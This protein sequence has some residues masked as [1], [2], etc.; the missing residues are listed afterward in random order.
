MPWS[1]F[2]PGLVMFGS[3][4][5]V[6]LFRFLQCSSA[7]RVTSRHDGAISMTP[8]TSL[9]EQD[10]SISTTQ[11]IHVQNMGVGLS[12]NT[13]VFSILHCKYVTGS[14]KRDHFALFHRF[15]QFSWY[16]ISAT[17]NKFVILS[18]WFMQLNGFISSS[19]LQQCPLHKPP[20]FHLDCVLYCGDMRFWSLCIQNYAN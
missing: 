13:R 7:S 5:Y 6:F 18:L 1:I 12:R 11:Y 10:G 8:E 17:I 3:P 16:H 9:Q 20:T 15:W 2:C 4:F 19:L 14:E